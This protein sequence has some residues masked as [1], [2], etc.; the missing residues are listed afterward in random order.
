MKNIYHKIYIHPLFYLFAVITILTG[1]FKAFLSIMNILLFH[2]LGHV[3]MGLILKWRIRRIIVLPV[4]CITEF[5]EK[6]N[7]PIYQE[8][9]ILICG[10]LFQMVLYMFYKTQYHY[11]LLIF[12]LLPIYPLDGSKFIFLLWNLIGSYYYSYIIT[13]I[14]SYITIFIL[15]IY[16]HNLMILLFS[17]Y[18][19]VSSIEIYYNKNINFYMFL[20]ERLKNIYPCYKEKII[21]GD[22]LK[23]M[24]RS[25]KHYFLIENSL[26][27]EKKVIKSKLNL[28][29]VSKVL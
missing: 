27:D 8:L 22:N 29:N 23:K 18:L 6:L 11:P 1:H 2:E 26:K 15:V 13:F 21:I 9:L 3:L 14:I 20:Y 16:Y 10:P 4:G 7:R 17:I 25:V 28:T 12:N 19:L 5:N 24:K